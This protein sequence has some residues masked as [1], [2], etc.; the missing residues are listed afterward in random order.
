MESTLFKKV[1]AVQEIF[2]EASG[3]S[4]KEAG[5]ISSF[6]IT[7]P[8]FITACGL[9]CA[10]LYA[11][12]FSADVAAGYIP[13]LVVCAG[14]S[15][16]LDGMTA[17][18]LQKH[19]RLGKVLD[20]LR[21]R[22]LGFVVLM[23][24]YFAEPRNMPLIASIL[25]LELAIGGVQLQRAFMYRLLTVEEISQRAEH[26]SGKIRQ[27]VHLIAAGIFVFQMYAPHLW[28]DIGIPRIPVPWLLA[29]MLAASAFALSM[30]FIRR[31]VPALSGLRF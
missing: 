25:A 9:V 23:N 24:M 18:L 15:D 2:S 3:W 6:I 27:A 21:D 19:S 7:I 4:Q 26:S 22:L 28:H 29:A 14:I 8:N 12:C 10:G 5:G 31:T 30:L 17:R 1:R 20:P 11:F 16:L 13:A